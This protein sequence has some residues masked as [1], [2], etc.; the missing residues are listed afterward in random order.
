MDVLESVEHGAALRRLIE[1]RYH[2]RWFRLTQADER[3]H[4]FAVNI[5]DCADRR[6]GHCDTSGNLE[7]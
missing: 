2:S 5:E 1:L 4:V 3:A 7:V 6:I